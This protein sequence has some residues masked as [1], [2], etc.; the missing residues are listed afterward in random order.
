MPAW[1][2]SDQF[3]GPLCFVTGCSFFA[4]KGAGGCGI[5]SA[6]L[7]KGA[8]RVIEDSEFLQP[9]SP[10]GS[11]LRQPLYKAL[12][13]R[14]AVDQVDW[15][16]EQVHAFYGAKSALVHSASGALCTLGILF[17]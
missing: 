13:M 11:H 4:V 8:A 17:L 3:L 7:C 16:T 6:G 9:F 14:K 1:S 15:T 2:A 12:W 10:P 5:S